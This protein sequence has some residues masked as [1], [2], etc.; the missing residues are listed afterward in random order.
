MAIQLQLHSDD[1]IVIRKSLVDLAG[2]QLLACMT[3][4]LQPSHQSVKVV[5]QIDAAQVHLIEDEKGSQQRRLFEEKEH[6]IECQLQVKPDAVL[7]SDGWIFDGELDDKRRNADKKVSVPN[8]RVP[9]TKALGPDLFF[10]RLLIQKVAL[11]HFLL[12]KAPKK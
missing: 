6:E 10:G 8:N 12:V 9:L 7:D 11:L 1:A 3:E 2:Q 5:R 4:R